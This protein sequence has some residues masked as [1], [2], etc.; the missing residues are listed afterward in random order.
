M[1]RKLSA[2]LLLSS[3]IVI[4]AVVQADPATD[5]AMDRA[6][7]HYKRSKAGGAMPEPGKGDTMKAGQKGD[8]MKSDMA[9]GEPVRAGAKG[10]MKKK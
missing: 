5:R 4:P 2:V 1:N 3:A 7:E 9:K 6:V 10:D 8:E